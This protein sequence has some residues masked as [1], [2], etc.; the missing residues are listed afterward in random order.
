M[1]EEKKNIKVELVKDTYLDY[2]IAGQLG[3]QH[4]F[5]R[6]LAE[7]MIKSGHAVE[8]TETKKDK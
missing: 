1:A 5:S 7:K 8:V 6:D 2:R 4:T 3:S